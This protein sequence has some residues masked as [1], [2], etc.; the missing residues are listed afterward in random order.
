MKVTIVHGATQIQISGTKSAKKSK[1]LIEDI[2]RLLPNEVVVEE[3]E[4]EPN[5]IGFSVTATVERSPSVDAA[6]ED[7]DEYEEWEW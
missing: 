5:P 6:A 2:F 7:E 3:E 1:K 4:E